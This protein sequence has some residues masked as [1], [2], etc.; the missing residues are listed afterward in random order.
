VPCFNPIP[1]WQDE[2][3]NANG[4]YPLDFSRHADTLHSQYDI[5]CGRCDGCRGDRARDWGVRLYHE[6]LEYDYSSF[7]TLTYNDDNCDGKVHREHINQFI[8]RLRMSPVFEWRPR[9]FWCAEYGETTHRP[10]YHLVAFGYDFTDHL[11]YGI[12]DGMHGHPFVD[13]AW[14]RG[15]VAIAP[16]REPNCLF[17]TAGYVQKK[18]NDPDTMSG[19]SRGSRARTNG[20][21]P[22]LG[23][24]WAERNLETMDRLGHVTIEGRP[25]PIPDAYMKWFPQELAN[26]KA[27]RAE[28]NTHKNGIKLRNQ[29]ENY[30]ARMALYRKEAI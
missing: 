21:L 11:S 14:Q 13:N 16:V 9:Y 18:R 5:R 17:Y 28:A 22:P 7:L 27:N 24:R 25:M 6:H 23:Y 12:R 30:R 1:A 15:E 2:E 3:P 29:Q 19:M 10:H 26:A 20:M 4:K 8:D